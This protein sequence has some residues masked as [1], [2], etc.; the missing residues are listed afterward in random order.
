MSLF[1]CLINKNKVER[2][3]KKKEKLKETTVWIYNKIQTKKN[4]LIYIKI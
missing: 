2:E 4:C 3:R 1:L